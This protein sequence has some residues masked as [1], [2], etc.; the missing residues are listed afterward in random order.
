MSSILTTIATIS[1][2]SVLALTASPDFAPNVTPLGDIEV[3]NFSY[4][5]ENFTYIK[6][7]TETYASTPETI[8]EEVTKFGFTQ[9]QIKSAHKF[10]T[11]K[12]VQD[13]INSPGLNNNREQYISFLESRKDY[14]EEIIKDLT[15]VD[16]PGTSF[17]PIIPLTT[18]E[19]SIPVLGI[20]TANYSLMGNTD[21]VL[22]EVSATEFNKTPRLT[23]TY[24][25]D[26]AY[27]V[28]DDNALDY[29]SSQ[30]GV[31]RKQAEATVADKI[32]E[33]GGV[34]WFKTHGQITFT[35]QPKD[36]GWEITE[37]STNYVYDVSDFMK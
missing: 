28:S 33:P 8:T 21:I 10:T 19:T 27:K 6:P 26:T 11:D 7:T 25:Y 30:P 22:K 3:I 12:L 29:V 16:K 34:N 13:Y 35:V 23:Y 18:P 24:E 20:D 9:D 31:T 2:T 15:P 1:L 37:L 36:T 4:M 14:N 5:E 17:Q 32:L